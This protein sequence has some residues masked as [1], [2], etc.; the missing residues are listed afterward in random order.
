MAQYQAIEKANGK[1]DKTIIALQNE[2]ASIRAGRAN[3][4]LLNRITVD[5]YGTQ[6][7]SPQVGNVS[8]PEPRLL[9]ISLW[10]ASMMKEVEKA[11][12]ASDLGLNPTNDGKMIRLVF[13]EPT[14]ERRLE[15]VKVARKKAEESKVAIRSIRR[16]ANEK[17]KKDKK[18][19]LITEDDLKSLEKEC[20]DMTDK[21]I[22]KIDA[23]LKEKESEI[24]EI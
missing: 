18:D 3:P 24:M 6:T 5:Y 14:Q 19:S 22:K 16:D 4:Q 15:L 23:L 8:S 1:M 11:I 13:P 10:D 12:L 7:P 9:T 20:Q 17:L 21:Y 2:F